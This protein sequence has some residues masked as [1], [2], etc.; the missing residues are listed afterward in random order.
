M[1]KW[2]IMIL[3]RIQN[4]NNYTKQLEGKRWADFKKGDED[5]D[6]LRL[7]QFGKE[8]WQIFQVQ[9]AHEVIF[10][11]KGLSNLTTYYLRRQLED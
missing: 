2:E 8:G 9:T 6:E 3:E 10:M 5:S 11:G 4:I 1:P 7:N